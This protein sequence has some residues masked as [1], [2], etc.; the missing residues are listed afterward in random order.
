VVTPQYGMAYPGTFTHLSTNRPRCRL[1]LVDVHRAECRKLR[2]GHQR[3]L[4]VVP[5][6]LAITVVAIAALYVGLQPNT[7][8][9][10]PASLLSDDSK[11]VASAKDSASFRHDCMYAPLYG[12]MRP[13][14]AVYENMPHDFHGKFTERV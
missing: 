9:D 11:A 5:G 4:T 12:E 6:A 1:T 3:G 2:L 7:V 8:C 13:F 14:T 10:S